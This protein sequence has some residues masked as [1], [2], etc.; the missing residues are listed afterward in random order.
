M[1][2]IVHSASDHEAQMADQ[3]PM[4]PAVEDQAALEW[5]S[6]RLHWVEYIEWWKGRYWGAV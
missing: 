3:A 6:K 2:I 5:R 1:I 4:A